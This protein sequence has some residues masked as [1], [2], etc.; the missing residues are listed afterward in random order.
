LNNYHPVRAAKTAG[1]PISEFFAVLAEPVHLATFERESATIRFDVGEDKDVQHW[2][3]TVTDG[4]VEVTR[5]NSPADAIV[6]VRR[7]DFEQIVTGRMNAQAALLRGVVSCEGS[8]G[9]LMMFQRCLPGPPGSKGRV[10][11]ISSE[12]VMAQRRAG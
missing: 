6:R 8:V 2:Y 11:P 5:R 1:D 10:A 9:A 3:V 4:D 12:T 7:P